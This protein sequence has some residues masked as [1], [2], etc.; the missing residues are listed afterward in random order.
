[1]RKILISLFLLSLILMMN[2]VTAVP[3]GNYYKQITINHTYVNGSQTDFPLM[4]NITGDSELS[5]KAQPSG[6]DIVFFAYDNITKLDHEIELYNSTAKQLVA[7]VKIPLL[8]DTTDTVINMYYNNSTAINTE[9]SSGVWGENA[10]GIWLMNDGAGDTVNDSSGNGNNGTINGT[11]WVADGLYF[12]ES[13]YV[14][15][16]GFSPDMVETKAYTI[17][18]GLNTTQSTVTWNARHVW[19]YDGNDGFGVAPNE[20]EKIFIY[21]GGGNTLV[22]SAIETPINDGQSHEIVAVF[23][24][25]NDIVNIY[26]DG[27]LDYQVTSY[28][29]N[30]DTTDAKV[31]IG[32]DN[33]YIGNYNGT[34]EYVHI[35]DRA[36]SAAEIVTRYNNTNSPSTFST[37]GEEVSAGT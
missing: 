21:T 10:L 18:Y 28:T 4:I 17:A 2:I 37:V 16:S 8:N 11:D 36:L 26:V 33:N 9:N 1:M 34:F 27:I 5:S 19:I 20:S 3:S 6:D 32:C 12:Y 31:Y 13:D 23:D 24:Q 22:D 14:E 7:W 15:V 30:S 35:Y 29:D 25:V